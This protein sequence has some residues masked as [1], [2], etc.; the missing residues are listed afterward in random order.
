MRLFNLFW[1]I[2]QRWWLQYPNKITKY[3]YHSNT[4]GY[5][6]L[7]KLVLFY[8]NFA[9]AIKKSIEG[10]RQWAWPTGF[11]LSKSGEGPNLRLS[12]TT[13]IQAA[14]KGWSLQIEPVYSSYY[15]K[16]MHVDTDKI[17]VKQGKNCIRK[18]HSI[19]LNL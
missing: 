18:P 13:L 8:E 17:L 9:A 15:R 16:N 19:A 12:L 14:L 2:Q 1:S 5:K 6:M 10:F 11:L 3:T 7:N 4:T